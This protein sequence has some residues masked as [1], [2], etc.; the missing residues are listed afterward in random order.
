MPI[1]VRIATLAIAAVVIAWLADG[2]AATTAQ[3]RL[4]TLTATAA[5]PSAA[6]LQQAAHLAAR[7]QRRSFDKRA[8]L[9]LGNLYLK[10]GDPAAAERV[11]AAAVR[12]EPENGEAWL[13]L[14]RAAHGRDPG[15]EKRALQRVRALA[16]PVPAP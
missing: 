12:A 9:F 11:T 3:Q 8:L 1:P 10:A 2:I 7:A 14:A 13:L 16:P 15:L 4:A 5:H 6:D